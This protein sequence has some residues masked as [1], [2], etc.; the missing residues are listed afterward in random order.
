MLRAAVGLLAILCAACSADTEPDPAGPPPE[1]IVVYASYADRNYLPMLFDAYTRQTG[2]P[3]IVRHA[4]PDATVDDLIENKITP[5]ADVL[6]TP[7]VR[8]VAR[9]AE[10]GALRPILSDAVVRRVAAPLRDPDDYWVAL[11]YRDAVIGFDPDRFGEA[12]VGAV[13]ALAD[14]KFRGQ[15]CLSS[16]TLATNRTV[17]AGLID[18]LG[19]RDAE[20]VVRGWI[21]NLASPVFE[22]EEQ[23]W[24]ATAHGDCGVSLLSNLGAAWVDNA[25]ESAVWLTAPQPAYTDVEAVGI[26]RHARN[27]DG[28][29]ALIEWLLDEETL[30]R[31]AEM[32]LAQPATGAYS[33]PQNVGYAAARDDEALLLAERARYY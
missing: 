33:G 21:A 19:M 13:A 5:P 12:E 8:G 10:E 32:T 15:L 7:T 4:D 3:V 14:P 16:A 1:P 18:R 9:A 25:S 28:G 11:T 31:H 22:T 27:P 24:R 30:H 29:R 26:G 23:L 17:I 6:M 2:V 20:I